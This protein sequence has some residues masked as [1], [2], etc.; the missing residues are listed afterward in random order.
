MP[1][2][3]FS[4]AAFALAASGLMPSGAR[5]QAYSYPS[6]QLPTVSN[7]DYTGAVAG[8]NG[9]VA[10]F[11]WREGINNDMHFSIDGGIGDPEGRNN[12]LMA[13]GAAGLARQLVRAAGE[14]PLDVLLTGG[15]GLALGGG[16]SLV[17]IPVGVSVGHRFPLDDGFALTPYVHPRVSLDL[18]S[19][20]TARNNDNSELTLN[21]D[22]GVNFEVNP[23]FSVR[24]AA[25][26]SGSELLGRNDS[27]AIGISW[28]PV[29][30]VRK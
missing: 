20:C 4:L 29:P 10:L 11:Q 26:F 5:A 25:S 23:K 30:L 9:T 21:F 24:A 22:V 2:L 7:R 12:S 13:F 16:A 8:A 27:F 17:R 14:Q 28:L 18:C 6:L 19:S 3:R 15:V 1:T